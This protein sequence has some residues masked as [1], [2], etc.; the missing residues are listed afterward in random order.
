MELSFKERLKSAPWYTKTEF[1]I[2]P[3]VVMNYYLSTLGIPVLGTPAAVLDEIIRDGVVLSIVLLFLVFRLGTSDFRFK[4]S[5]H[6]LVIVFLALSAATVLDTP[7][8]QTFPVGYVPVFIGIA[9]IHILIGMGAVYSIFDTIKPLSDE[10]IALRSKIEN[11]D[12]VARITG[13]RVLNDKILGENA[14]V[15]NDILDITATLTETMVKSNQIISRTVD[16]LSANT[17]ELSASVEEVTASTQSM[18]QGASSQ[19][20]MLLEMTNKQAEGEKLVRQ[21]IEQ[22]Q[23]NTEQV[24]EIAIQTN[25]LALNA[26]IEASRAGDYGRGFAVVAENVRRLA[27]SSTTIADQIKETAEEATQTLE[28]YFNEMRTD[29][30]QIAAISEETSASSEE[31]AATME[32]VSANL[33]H[34]TELTDE[35]VKLVEQNRK[36]L[37]QFFKH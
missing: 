19:T 9:L 29:V 22:I 27:E 36:T 14:K 2:F 16:S 21:I 8:G 15:V 5:L 24:S 6:V 7:E 28:R 10:L 4:V 17:E 35:L 26:G 18:A 25:I 11:G 33:S 20:D 37:D 31:I 3:L 23:R 30:E 12:L 1:L 13:K 34:M 32:D